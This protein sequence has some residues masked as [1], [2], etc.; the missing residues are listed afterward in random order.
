MF[1]TI[2]K[3][4][5]LVNGKIY[6]GKHQTK[7]M[8]DGYMGSGKHL[9]RSI[10]KYG[11]ENF[12]KEILFQFDNESD[13]NA[14]EAELV[15]EEFVKEDTNYNLCPGGQG[16]WGY[17]NTSGL[18]NKGHDKEMY[19]KV[20]QTLK[21]KPKYC[22]NHPN[23]IK[24]LKRM[25]SEGNVKYNTFTGKKHTK[26]TKQKM[27]NSR[28]N[29]GVGES[30]SQFGKFWITNGKE[31]KKVDENTIVEKGW[32]KGRSYIPIFKD[33]KMCAECQTVLNDIFWWEKFKQSN[34]TVTKFVNEIYPY[35][36]ATFYNM[37]SRLQK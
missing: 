26:E 13:M 22:Y 35:N 4:T 12:T 10:D 15:T 24:A 36:R 19:N 16:G 7:D 34:M 2:Y 25:H 37:K 21:N 23:K 27:S 1:Y 30:N 31:N 8:N 29:T 28:K 18:R 3:I 20:S 17:V 5:N 33:I 14:K 6:I 11:I 9:K 32:W